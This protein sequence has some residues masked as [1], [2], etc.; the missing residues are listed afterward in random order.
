MMTLY[1]LLGALPQD[2]A[3]DVRAA[4]RKAV[5]TAHPDTNPDDPNA[6][7]RLRM[8]LRANAILGDP[9]QRAAYDRLLA[10]AA[11]QP[12]PKPKRAAASRVIRKLASDA[13]AVAA[14]STLSIGGYLVF[15]QLSKASPP[16]PQVSEA[17]APPPAVVAQAPQLAAAVPDKPDAVTGAR[18]G[19]PANRMSH[20]PR[21]TSDPTRPMAQPPRRMRR[22]TSPT[23]K[24]LPG[25]CP[26]KSPTV[27]PPAR[28]SCRT[29]IRPRRMQPALRQRQTRPTLPQQP[30]RTAL[31]QQ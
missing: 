19:P 31:Q 28:R 22:L 1:D 26:P 10:S 5:K 2:N 8:I 27:P 14:V 30:A 4:F 20:R 3:D 13:L 12:R 7:L 17:D 29:R 6:E 21:P 25:S 9:E 23:A 15:E 16:P 24:P 18:D 11:A